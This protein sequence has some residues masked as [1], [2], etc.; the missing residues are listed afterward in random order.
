MKY[1]HVKACRDK[2]RNPTRQRA[3]SQL[4]TLIRYRGAIPEH[5]HIY[6]CDNCGSWHVGHMSRAEQK[7]KAERDADRRRGS[8]RRR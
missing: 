1:P 2:F 5:Y 3:E 4:D 6:R 7:R 8:R